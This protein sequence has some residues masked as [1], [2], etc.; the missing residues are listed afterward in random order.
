MKKKI[1]MIILAVLLTAALAV[2]LVMWMS[3]VVEYAGYEN[4]YID[5]VSDA[6]EY[7]PT[8]T[9][10][11]DTVIVSVPSP[12]ATPAIEISVTPK[13]EA[14]ST[15]SDERQETRQ[16]VTV[17]FNSLL[18]QNRDTVAWLFI[19]GT[20]INYPVVQATDNDYYLN[21]NFKRKEAS[22]GALFMDYQ[23]SSAPLDRNTVV[24]GHNMNNSSL[25]FSMLTRYKKASYWEDH[26]I[27][28]FDTPSEPGRWC[29]FAVCHLDT[30]T[31][32]QF[33]FLQQDFISDNAFLEY[34][35]A[36]RARALYDTGVD[37]PA[38]GQLLTLVTCDRSDGFGKTGRLIVVAVRL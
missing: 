34:A 12:S 31:M 1:L 27:L 23:N 3:E 35:D 15:H 28:Q 20:K 10:A 25:M 26:A 18:S 36:L 4:D 37:V 19:P 7:D 16:S 13:P 38:G 32:E 33:N 8:P 17:D 24:F 9:K 30:S 21:R 5:I 11:P 6:V 14:D 22:C 29:V 2:L